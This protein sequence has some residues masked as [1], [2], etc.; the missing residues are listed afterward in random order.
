M[1]DVSCTS[2]R[3]C[4][5]NFSRLRVLERPTPVLERAG[6]VAVGF[7]AA[8][9]KGAHHAIGETLV[10]EV[11]VD[12]HEPGDPFRVAA[13]EFEREERTE[14]VADEADRRLAER[15]V[16]QTSEVE[17]HVV[18]AVALL[19]ALAHTVA[20]Q[21][22]DEHVG[23]LGGGA[24]HREVPAGQVVHHETVD[25]HRADPGV[26]RAEPLVVQAYAVGDD[27]SHR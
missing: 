13:R 10:A 6:D 9:R 11:A 24:G 19:R 7:F 18:D 27:F 26:R 1:R 8:E 22:V 5:A 3:A 21:I 4:A 17:H 23:E 20:A 15:R 16:E 12:Q 14:A 25:E 2:A